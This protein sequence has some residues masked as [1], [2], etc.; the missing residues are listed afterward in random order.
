MCDGLT[1]LAQ[2]LAELNIRDAGVSVLPLLPPSVTRFTV[3][4]FLSLLSEPHVNTVG[5]RHAAQTVSRPAIRSLGE[6][7]QNRVGLSA[8]LSQK[9]VV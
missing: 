1:A 8:R 5:R 7:V 9:C 4:Q 2:V 6:C 3:G